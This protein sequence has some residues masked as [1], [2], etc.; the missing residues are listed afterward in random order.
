MSYNKTISVLGCGWLGL[1][2][3][4]YLFT[5]GYSVKGSTTSPLKINLMKERGLESFILEL[6]P[7]ISGNESA[8]FF[9]SEILII[10][11]PPPRGENA[12]QFHSDQIYSIMKAAKH[13]GLR[14][15]VFISST[16]VYGNVNREVFEDEDSIPDTKSGLALKSVE[17]L[18]ISNPDFKTTIIRFGG[19]VGPGRNISN[20]YSE[21][22]KI[23][24]PNSPVNLIHLDDCIGI[25]YQV[26]KE[27]CWNEIFNAAAPIHPMR[28]EI[29]AAA[30]LKAEKP[31][32]EFDYDFSESYKIIN[33]TKLISKLKYSFIH[34]DPLEFS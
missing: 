9:N 21:G 30:A 20:F 3:A 31:Q 8:R 7:E 11:I 13:S 5:K 10:N 17:R 34:S 18:L 1:P 26:I 14:K 25:I 16:S 6:N 19:L 33:P 29:Y 23:K 12:V 22:S 28:R 32:P 27:N 15:L 4:S 24:S 2:L